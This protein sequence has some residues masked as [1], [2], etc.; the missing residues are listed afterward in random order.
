MKEKIEH[1][2]KFDNPYQ[3]MMQGNG[4]IGSLCYGDKE[5]KFSLDLASL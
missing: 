1:V 3:A 2:G 4:N 5:L